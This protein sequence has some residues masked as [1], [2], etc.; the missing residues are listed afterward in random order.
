MTAS[1]SPAPVSDLPAAP[2][3]RHPL[4]DLVLRFP[5]DEIGRRQRKNRRAREQR[6]RRRVPD[7]HDAIGVGK[8]QRPQHHG[9]DDRKNRGVDADAEAE[10]QHAGDGEAGA[11]HQRPGAI[12][13][14]AD[15][16]FEHRKT[17]AIAISLLR[18]FDA[19][20][21]DERAATRFRAASFRP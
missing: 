12:T 5:V 9:V 13:K 3:N 7:P 6:R 2:V 1:G 15:D 20:E 14:I 10:N 16:R 4:E 11:L 18:L 17:A 8:R 19:A 21:R